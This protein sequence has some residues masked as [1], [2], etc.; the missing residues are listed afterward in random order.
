MPLCPCGL[1]ASIR[2][3]LVLGVCSRP[4]S[5]ESVKAVKG[6]AMERR[7][8][9]LSLNAILK[10]QPLFDLKRYKPLVSCLDASHLY[11]SK[12]FKEN[13]KFRID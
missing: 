6:E 7:W 13:L 11:Q 8:V 9:F 4:A 3:A 12:Y 10:F 2:A 1:S 5:P